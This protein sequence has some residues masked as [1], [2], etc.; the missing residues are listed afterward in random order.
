[1]LYKYIFTLRG[2]IL[3]LMMW[4]ET[5]LYPNDESRWEAAWPDSSEWSEDVVE[6]GTSRGVEVA[7]IRIPC[8]DPVSS[9]VISYRELTYPPKHG[10]LKMIFLFP[11]WDMLIPWRVSYRQGSFGVFFAK[12]LIVRFQLWGEYCKWLIDPWITTRLCVLLLD[13]ISYL[14]S[15]CRSCSSF[16]DVPCFGLY[17]WSFEPM[18][19]LRLETCARHYVFLLHDRFS[20]ITFSSTILNPYFCG[21]QVVFLWG[22]NEHHSEDISSCSSICWIFIY[23]YMSHRYH[24][25]GVCWH[26]YTYI[27]I[28]TKL[29][30]SYPI[31]RNSW[32]QPPS[33][34]LDFF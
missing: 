20:Q 24:S 28:Y 33:I 17:V 34:H 2:V 6:V 8:I 19:L 32:K 14:I 25:C 18:L 4:L 13:L 29:S 10:I 21:V 16:F 11:R 31:K 7:E 12:K 23:I 22:L 5:A 1:M 9:E 27:Y 15:L 30:Y 3:Y 26:I